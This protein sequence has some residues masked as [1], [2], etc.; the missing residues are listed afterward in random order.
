MKVLLPGFVDLQVNGFAGVDFNTPGQ[1]ADQIGEALA[2]MRTTGVTRCLPTLITSSLERFAACVRPI[3]ACADPA[4]A[5]LHIEGPYISPVDG[6]RGAH[7][8]SEVIAASIEDFRRRQEAAAGRIRLVT[9]APEVAGALGLIEYLVGQDV[10]VGIGHT[11]ATREQIRAAVSAGATLSTHLGNGCA[12]LLPR[13]D[14]V[15]WE[16]LADD[17]LSASLIIDGHHLPPAV[18]KSMIRAKGLAR[19]ILVTDAV[20][21]A[22]MPPGRYWLGD[23]EGELDANGRVTQP[24]TP[25]L[26]GSALT[27]DAAVANA[28]RFSGLALEEVL[29]LA[30]TQPAHYLG[31]E[32][33]GQVAA[34]WTPDDHRLRIGD[35]T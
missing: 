12:Q 15:I 9:L 5:G 6:A 31:I 16:Q 21:A 23:L 18:V 28:A 3:L 17:E 20:S 26:A 8:C 29:P 13:H 35:A 4:I 11:S 19:T 1:S 24:G 22:S 25:Y 7:P 2:A 10:R 14:N 33:A 32:P 30:T 34:E 27:M